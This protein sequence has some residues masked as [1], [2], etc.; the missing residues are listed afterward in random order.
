MILFLTSNKNIGNVVKAAMAARGSLYGATTRRLLH[1]HPTTMITKVT[2]TSNSIGRFPSNRNA[3]TAT[4]CLT[5]S[6]IREPGSAFFH[7]SSSLKDPSNRV[8]DTPVYPEDEDL[9]GSKA[10][11]ECDRN[12]LIDLFHKFAVDCD[13]S[14]RYLNLE[15]LRKLLKA[16][17]EHLDQAT[18]ERLFQAAD[19][20]GNGN[21]E[22]TVRILL[23]YLETIWNRDRPTLMEPC[24]HTFS[25]IR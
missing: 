10:F 15:G 3:G 4:R 20:D 8:E 6:S 12:A 1:S 5:S 11:V 25:S 17:G 2:T 23:R 13:K 18:L 14:G 19:M 7:S 16:V 24:P 9:P 22:L 21:I